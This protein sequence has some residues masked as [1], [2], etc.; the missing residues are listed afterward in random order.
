MLAKKG[1]LSIMDHDGLRPRS[2]A[3]R[4]VPLWRKIESERAKEEEEQ[5]TTKRGKLQP[6]SLFPSVGWKIE[7]EITVEKNTTAAIIVMDSSIC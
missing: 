5:M 1:L 7:V 3:K 4:R 2:L 6:T